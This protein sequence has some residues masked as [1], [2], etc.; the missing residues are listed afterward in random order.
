MAPWRSLSVASKRF[1]QAF[2]FGCASLLCH[3]E[4]NGQACLE[5]LPD[6]P[7]PPDDQRFLDDFGAALRRFRGMTLED[8]RAELGPGAYRPPGVRFIRGDANSDGKV[9]LSDAICALSF[10]FL[11]E[12][13][14][15]APRCLS[16]LDAD[17]TGT[18][19][20]SDPIRTSGRSSSVDRPRRRPSPNR[21]LIPRRTP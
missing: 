1:L 18:I 11:G 10:L 14:C 21:G 9:N 8:L 7:S 13:P 6:V 12:G 4:A 2:A 3:E 19:L 20:L 17:D 15:A 5:R 16:A